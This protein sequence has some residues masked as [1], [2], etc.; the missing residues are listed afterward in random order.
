MAK[1]NE[2]YAWKDPGFTEGSV[3][4]PKLSSLAT[5]PP[6][7]W[8]NMSAFSSDFQFNPSKGRLFAETKIKVP[9][10]TAKDWSYLKI[11]MDF[12]NPSGASPFTFYAFVD[13]VEA[14][15][16][17]ADYPLCVVRFH[18]DLWRTYAN[19]A[20]YG[21]GTVTRRPRGADDPIQKVTS[22]Y[23]VIDDTVLELVPDSIVGS[24]AYW[25]IINYTYEDKQAHTTESR[26]IVCP[27]AKTPN[28]VYYMRLSA[29]S[30]IYPVP[31][32][33]DWILG[34][35]DE[36][37]GLAPSSISSVFLS[38][39][40]PLKLNSGTGT[41]NDPF[42]VVGSSPAPTPT[43]TTYSGV[44]KRYPVSASG[45][46]IVFSDGSSIDYHNWGSNIVNSMAGFSGQGS[47]SVSLVTGDGFVY[48]D[49]TQV[50]QT[51]TWDGSSLQNNILSAVSVDDYM[52]A[53]LGDAVFNSLANGDTVEFSN[54]YG[55]YS[56]G[57]I[58]QSYESQSAGGSVIVVNHWYARMSGSQATNTTLTYNNG[59]FGSFW[60]VVNGIISQ[61]SVT[62]TTYTEATTTAD[63]GFET[64]DKD[65]VTYAYLYTKTNK[66]GEYSAVLSSAIATSD[67][68]E[69]IITD[70]D[71]S[72]VGS[73]PWGL[74]V[75]EYTFRCVVSA[76][77]A[78]VQFRF[79]GLNSSAEGLQFSIPL[80]PLDISSN[81]WS[82]YLYSGQRDFDVTQKRIVRERSLVE[83][84][85]GGLAMGAQGAMLGGLKEGSS[86]LPTAR[87]IGNASLFGAL[88]AGSAIA[89]SLV[90][91]ASA[92][93]FN[94][95][96]QSATD[97]LQAKQIDSIITAGN[98]CDWLYYGRPYQIRSLVPDAY[99]L[100]RFETDVS[101][102]GLSVS[103]PTV[104]CDAMIKSATGPLTIENLV[105][106]GNIPVEAKQYLKQ[107]FNDGVRLI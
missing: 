30:T 94:D 86:W 88:G 6:Y 51:P 70:V 44:N 101:L 28:T 60:V 106:R 62:L 5:L 1:I 33:N 20:T 83:G 69:Y 80:P 75:S 79:N 57:S 90:N 32:L 10:L 29:S 68:K 49:G 95:K 63:Y 42:V 85:A 84:L 92:G 7:D 58:E 47:G 52:R 12:N 18:I 3:E 103:E 100:S 21:S 56:Q 81:S 24:G 40:P 54:I 53:V 67:T 8:Y 97:L 36:M 23:K 107:K 11:V 82:E 9:Y 34:N 15:S 59:S 89:G 38:P 26:V 87:S 99:S 13:S 48:V 2:L 22:R 45:S 73:F 76:T 66:F 98:G 39:V 16:D 93:Y 102:N 4:V 35:Y 43:T 104:S 74:T 64:G 55:L 61:S 46:T 17:T 50:L 105:V 72:V 71:G 19:N 25:A 37:F 14:E 91:Y 77:S 31:T 27:V 65:G 96:L 78:Y 41:L